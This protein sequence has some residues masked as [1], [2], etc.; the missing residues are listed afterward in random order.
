MRSQS[1]AAVSKKHENVTEGLT[2]IY[3]VRQNVQG[4]DLSGE[5]AGSTLLHIVKVSI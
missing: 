2:E 5:R 3:V 4:N 1:I